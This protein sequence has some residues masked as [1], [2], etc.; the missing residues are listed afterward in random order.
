MHID[1]CTEFCL[2]SCQ[3]R[4]ASKSIRYRS[5][6]KTECGCPS[7]GGIKNGHIRYPSYGGRQKERQEKIQVQ[8][9]DTRRTANRKTHDSSSGFPLG[10]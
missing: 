10:D 2:G 1:L 4:V 5:P 3:H 8:Q 7:G 9:L 6:P